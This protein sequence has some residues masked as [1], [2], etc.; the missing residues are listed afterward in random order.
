MIKMVSKFKSFFGVS[1]LVL[2]Y[3]VTSVVRADSVA[4]TPAAAP[5]YLQQIAANTRNLLGAVNVLP[6][7][8]AQLVAMWITPDTSA[9]TTA[10]QQDFSAY[11]NALATGVNAQNKLQPQL[12]NS[13]FP[14]GTTTSTFPNAN[15]Y[16]YQT[17]VGLPFYNPDPRSKTDPAYN[18][19]LNASGLLIQ[20]VMPVS[21]WRGEAADQLAYSNYVGAASAV[22]TFNGYVL[23]K[24]YTDTL[25]GNQVQ[26]AQNALI[27]QATSSDWFAEIASEPIS[28]VIRQLLMF[29]SQ[30]YITL[31]QIA[32][33]QQQML[34]AQAMSNTL[35]VLSGS[36]SETLMLTKAKQKLPGT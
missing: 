31:T 17:M 24:V 32:Q 27:T 7:Y 22:Q 4:T 3:F 33:N 18:Y 5:D 10:L 13:F 25:G 36:A 12:L 30:M 28:S 11:T 15:D 6:A 9:I 34:I 20:H 8:L 21:T 16:A 35:A 26:I 23:S 14:A 29:N 19:L 1:L 2:A